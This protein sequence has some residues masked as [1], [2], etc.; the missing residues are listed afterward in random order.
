MINHRFSM[1][2]CVRADLLGL[3]EPKKN[4]MACSETFFL[5]RGDHTL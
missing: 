2:A 1:R 4:D 5:N 3:T